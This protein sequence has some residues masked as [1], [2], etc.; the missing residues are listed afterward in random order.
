MAFACKWP[1]HNLSL[2]FGDLLFLCQLT[3]ARVIYLFRKPWILASQSGIEIRTIW[4]FLSSEG[5]LIICGMK[6]THWYF[7]TSTFRSKNGCDDL[8]HSRCGPKSW[9]C[10]FLRYNHR[11]HGTPIMGFPASFSWFSPH[12]WCLET[13][14]RI[15]DILAN[16]QHD[17]NSSPFHLLASCSNYG[18]GKSIINKF[19]TPPPLRNILKPRGL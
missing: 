12:F 7:K 5:F 4:I 14:Y 16:Y 1:C 10:Y 18:K 9:C 15:D 3:E 6:C 13:Q 19:L 2:E 11:N 17:P 8:G